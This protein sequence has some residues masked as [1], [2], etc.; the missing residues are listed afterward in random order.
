VIPVRLH[1]LV[2]GTH[3]VKLTAQPSDI[4]HL[5]TEFCSP[6]TVG[7]VVRK[8]GKRVLIEIEA[9]TDATLECDRSLESFLEPIT[10]T[11]TLNVTIDSVIAS[12]QRASTEG[13]TE[14]EVVAI[15]E[16]VKEIDIADDVRQELVVALPMRR[17][18]PKYRNG[19]IED[20]FPLL[21]PGSN[22]PVEQPPSAMWAAL[23]KL[24]Q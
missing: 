24:K 6:I 7:V 12:M 19:E 3:H 8:N 23:Q 11:F 14:R 17:V 9:T 4:P 22:Q 2:D 10:V 20:V 21:L 13:S 1:G 16:E 15:G 5:S 18:S